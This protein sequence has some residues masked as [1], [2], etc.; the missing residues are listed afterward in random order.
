MYHEVLQLVAVTA[1]DKTS[2]FNQKIIFV[3][4]FKDESARKNFG[5]PRYALDGTELE[6]DAGDEAYH[7]LL[8]SFRHLRRNCTRVV[9]VYDLRDVDLII[10]I[11]FTIIEPR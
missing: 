7:L 1:D 5:I 11:I 6:L 9:L 8:L 10:I 3:H 2:L 4:G